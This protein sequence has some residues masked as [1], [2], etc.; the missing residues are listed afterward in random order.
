MKWLIIVPN[1]SRNSLQDTLAEKAAL[2][3]YRETLLTVQYDKISHA[4][5]PA[6]ISAIKT[7]IK[8]IPYF[9]E[10]FI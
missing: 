9:P 3:N 1:S 4:V 10:I 5:L 6:K 2:N 8:T 7:Q